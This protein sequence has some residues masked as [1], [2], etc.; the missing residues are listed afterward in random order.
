MNELVKRLMNLILNFFKIDT[1]HSLYYIYYMNQVITQD[2]HTLIESL[3]LCYNSKFSLSFLYKRYTPTITIQ[4]P[5]QKKK[6]I[7]TS[8]QQNFI[9]PYYNRCIARTWNNGL[10]QYNP[11]TQK[12]SYGLQCSRYK[13][14]SNYCL[15]HYKQFITNTLKHGNF[16]KPPPHPHYLK[17]KYKIEK[18]FKIIS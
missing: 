14:K 7:V 6:R 3:A 16:N 13:S 15:T 9:P 1:F 17:F 4:S 8:K 11:I 18:Q 2:I 10:T 12:W 5:I